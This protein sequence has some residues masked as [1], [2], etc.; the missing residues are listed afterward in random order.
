ME[1]MFFRK[2][3]EKMLQKLLAKVRQQA[4][5][6]DTH[7]SAGAA[8]AELSALESIVGTKVS[9]VEKKGARALPAAVR[10]A[11]EGGGSCPPTQRDTA[12]KAPS[13]GPVSLQRCSS[14]STRLTRLPKHLIET[15]GRGSESPPVW[16]E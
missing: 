12:L 1:D 15:F 3:E 14:G 5:H 6:A 8:A 11:L 10:A 7:G 16:S 4:H 2:E 13:C 9:D